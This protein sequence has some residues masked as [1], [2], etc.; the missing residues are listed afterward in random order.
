M[1]IQL[2]Q[3]EIEAAINL[4]L[5]TKG[6]DLRAKQVNM[7]FTAG[8]R[9]TGLSVDVSIEDQELPDF[10]DESPAPL[11]LVKPASTELPQTERETSAVADVDVAK[12][13]QAT[14]LFS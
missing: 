1:Q 2:K 12:P 9:E 13:T 6:I 10:F 5:T 11:A 8:R 14:S 7:A 3:A 4:Y